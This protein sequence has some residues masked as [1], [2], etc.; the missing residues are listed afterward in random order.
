MVVGQDVSLIVENH[1]RTLSG[2]LFS[3]HRDAHHTGSRLHGGTGPVDPVAGRRRS[4][5][6]S[7]RRQPNRGQK[8]PAALRRAGCLTGPPWSAGRHETRSTRTGRTV[9]PRRHAGVDIDAGDPL[10]VGLTVHRVRVLDAV[11]GLRSSQ[12]A[13]VVRIKRITVANLHEPN[14]MLGVAPP[15]LDASVGPSRRAAG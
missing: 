4:R 5:P 10:L 12:G 3:D 1:S 13:R 7:S 15:R 8:D 6:L 2:A 11:R 9:V 14:P